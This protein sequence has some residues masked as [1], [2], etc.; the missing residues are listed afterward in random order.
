MHRA[1]TFTLV[2]T[3]AFGLALAGAAVADPVDDTLVIETEDG[4]VELVT[5]RAGPDHLKDVV[6]TIYSGWHYRED[7]TRDLQRDDFDNP[8]MVFV[9]RGLD[10][11]N[12][13]IGTNGESCAGCHQGPETMAGLRA[14]T[15][16]VDEKT[17]DADDGRELRRR[18]R[19]R[20]Y[21]SGSLGLDRRQDEGH[22]GPDLDAV[23]RH[24]GQRG[25][26]RPGSPVL[27]KG[28][29]NLLHPLSASWRCP[30]PIATKTIRASS[31][32]PTT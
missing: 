5:S 19:D 6:D 13:A 28:Q 10:L 9:D 17:G 25:H 32:A 23:A 29:G 27:G 2:A 12:E 20:T 18:L 15:P 30:A 24:A 3:D 11:W 22:A 1:A 7:E 4:T 8:G 26:R 16:R 14:V 21:G 31:S